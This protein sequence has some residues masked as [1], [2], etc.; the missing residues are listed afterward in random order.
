MGAYAAVAVSPASA[1][2]SASRSVPISP[3][4]LYR[5]LAISL[6]SV[7]PNAHASGASRGGEGQRQSHPGSRAMQVVP[8]QSS[9]SDAA[10]PRR[11]L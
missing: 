10:A 6:S 9:L 1:G 2:K 8:R 4:A 5:L 3:S 7:R 11:A